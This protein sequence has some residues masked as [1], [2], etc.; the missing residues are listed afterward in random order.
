MFGD[1]QQVDGS[2]NIQAGRDV[3][4]SITDRES[5]REHFTDRLERIDQRINA[6]CPSG[7]RSP[8]AENALQR[9]Q[10]DKLIISMARSGIPIQVGLDVAERLEGHLRLVM[11]TEGQSTTGHVRQAVMDCIYSLGSTYSKGEIQAWADIYARRYGNPT[12]RLTVLHRDNTSEDLNF[13]FLQSQLIPHLVEKILQGATYEHLQRAEVITKSAAKRMAEDIL[14]HVKSLNVYSIRYK[15]LFNIAY[16]LA[17][18][19]P[20]PWFVDVDTKAHTV[21]YDIERATFHDLLLDGLLG[22]GN[23]LQCRHSIRE[24]VH[25]SCSAILAHYGAFLG[26]HHMGSLGALTHALATA[27]SDGNELLWKG[28]TIQQ[29][30]GDLRA[31]GSSRERLIRDLN[32]VGK[33]TSAGDEALEGTV[34]SVHKLVE[35]ARTLVAPELH[36]ATTLQ[37]LLESPLLDPVQFM[38]AAMNILRRVDGFEGF[39]RIDESSA[40]LDHDIYGGL[41][42]DVRSRVLI[43][44]VVSNNREVSA[45]DVSRVLDVTRPVVAEEPLANCVILVAHPG[46]ALEARQVVRASSTKVSLAFLIQGSDLLQIA[47]SPN[48]KRALVEVLRR[49]TRVK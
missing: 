46:I 9:F 39:E 22:G 3:T 37:Q 43:H 27:A 16:D 28:S 6:L 2:N 5:L 12:E 29:I 44:S 33:N 19:P 36:P 34:A 45:S 25:H 23:S 18:Q 40:W 30:E 38:D 48:R 26:A 13:S 17:L 49:S 11:P 41:F 14:D 20:H 4:I 32:R 31:I 10:S 8:T 21:A 15:T 1:R 47:V 42:H 7:F 35:L 24:S